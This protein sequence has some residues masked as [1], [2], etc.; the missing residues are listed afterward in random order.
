MD[1]DSGETLGIISAGAAG[2]T[3][4][5]CET[6]THEIHEEQHEWTSFTTRITATTMALLNAANEGE[7]EE[8]ALPLRY[9]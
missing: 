8:Q 1:V 2:K 9:I 7:E 6:T 4:L 5:K 3:R